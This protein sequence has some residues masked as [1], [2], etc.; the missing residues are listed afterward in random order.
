MKTKV[1]MKKSLSYIIIV[2]SFFGQMQAQ[3]SLYW[4][5]LKLAKAELLARKNK[6]RG[7]EKYFT[8]DVVGLKQKLTNVTSKVSKKATIEI[9]IPNI[10]GGYETYLVSEN[11]NFDPILQAKY[12]EIRSY[13][14]QGVSDISATLHFSMS[15]LG[16]Q[17]VVFRGGHEME[18]IESYD[19][20]KNSYVIFDS[21]KSRLAYNCG[22]P[23]GT[24]N[25]N[26]KTKENAKVSSSAK[27]FKTLRLA[28]SCNGEYAQ[29]FGGTKALALA[30]M[31][32]SLTRINAIFE[33]DFSVHMNLI[34]NNDE[35]IYLNPL[36]DPYSNAV[37]GVQNDTWNKEVQNTLSSKI[38][39]GA[40]D[41][42]HLF[43]KKG[44]GGNAG[45]IGC[46]CVDDDIANL[47]DINKGG[48]Y[49]SPESDTAAPSGDVFDF[50]FAAHEFGHQL[51]ATHTFSYAFE[52]SVSQVEP[53]SGCTTMGYAGVT[54]WDVQPHNMRNFAYVSI[55]QVQDN[56]A[57]K[58][59]PV[60]ITTTNATPVVSAGL[61]Y[62]IPKGTAF[63][64]TGTATDADASDVL[65]YSWEQNDPS[66]E[67]TAGDMSKTLDSKTFGPTFRIQEPSTSPMR[68]MPKLSSV[69][70]GQLTTATNWETVS[71]V[72]R[73]L[74]F[75]FTVRDNHPIESQTNTATMKVSVLDTAGPFEV[76]SQNATD[77]IYAGGSSQTISWNVNNTSTI[78]GSANVIVLLSTDGGLS[79]STTLAADVPNS[80]SATVVMPN[81]ASAN[82][83]IMVKPV[84]NIYYAVNSKEFSITHSLSTAMFSL[85]NFALYPTVNSGNFT[86]SFSSN[87]NNNVKVFV[88]DVLGKEV[89][90]SSYKK[91]AA[92]FSQEIQIKNIK[93]GVYFVNVQDG[94]KKD[95]KKI[96]V[97]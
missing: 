46:I 40:Y 48:G 86:L 51:G 2:L 92:Y 72:A 94:N 27:S 5:E 44:G 18:Y 70:L 79:F 43:C 32:A 26:Q 83:R 53:G 80:G 36:T 90:F 95:V 97:K 37:D 49:T 87:T 61:N 9:S 57:T 63:V 16:M 24:S 35:L 8:L 84:S 69:I 39:N 4:S 58:T 22:A 91:T 88:N 6:D 68:Y 1:Q 34:A 38:G 78:E 82:C 45:C 33:K 15:P 93:S 19:S 62:T 73:D 75:T 12:P 52:D 55:K 50:D 42:G 54:D 10:K 85:D 31:N 96:I 76:T 65:T 60:S 20:S 7:T 25:I 59:C 77:I 81:T 29:H 74:N 11:S 23:E 41:I 56:L 71:N 64:L 21:N 67:S 66:T 28:L 89:F 17:T 3:N 30:G 14:G 47:T 13:V